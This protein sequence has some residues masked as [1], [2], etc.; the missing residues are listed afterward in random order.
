MGTREILNSNQLVLVSERLKL[1]LSGSI[2]NKRGTANIIAGYK[3][4]VAGKS[5]THK[6]DQ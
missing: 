2:Q 5:R 4:L 6:K 3:L 1:S